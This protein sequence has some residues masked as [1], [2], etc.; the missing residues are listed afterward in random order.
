MSTHYTATVE[1]T[2]TVNTPAKPN[3]RGY[4]EGDT[5]VPASREVVELA[6]IVIRANT[7]DALRDKLESHVALLDEEAS[8]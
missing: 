8:S 6:R 5:T 7:L 1:V 4:F 3:A 2:K